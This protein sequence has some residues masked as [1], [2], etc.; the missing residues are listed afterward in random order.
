MLPNSDQR[1][2]EIFRLTTNWLFNSTQIYFY[3]KLGTEKVEFWFLIF[4]PPHFLLYFL[5][6]P[7]LCALVSKYPSRSVPE[8]GFGANFDSL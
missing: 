2:A 6:S 3:R 4:P 5:F 7:G 8:L 1:L